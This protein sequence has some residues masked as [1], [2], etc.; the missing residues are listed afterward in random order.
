M[1]NIARLREEKGWTQE[2]LASAV[3]VTR[4]TVIGWEADSRLPS[5]EK[6]DK[7]AKALDCSIYDIWP[8][9]SAEQRKNDSLIEDMKHFMLKEIDRLLDEIMQLYP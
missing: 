2:Q 5:L 3:G 9:S 7:L 1:N 4:Y 8:L 6:A